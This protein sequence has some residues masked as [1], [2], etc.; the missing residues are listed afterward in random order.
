MPFVKWIFCCVLLAS[1]DTKKEQRATVKFLMHQGNTP[2]QIWCGLQAVYEDRALSKTAVWF[3]CRHLQGGDVTVSIK[4]RPRTGRPRSVRTQENAQK[5]IQFLTTDARKT[6]TEIAEE[7]G[8]SRS[9][10]HNILKK[11]L[12]FSKLAPKFVPHILTDEQ[13]AARVRMCEYNLWELMDDP[14]YLSKV[15]TGDETWVSVFE[16]ETKQSSKHWMKG[17][18]GAVHPQKA[19]HNRSVKKAMLTVFFDSKGMVL[20]QFKAPKE[21][22]CADSYC[23]VLRD[24]RQAI[25]RK[26]PH[27]WGGGC[28]H[29]TFLLH[30]DNAPPH[31]AAVTLGLIGSHNID[32]VAHPPYSPDL[33][34]CDFFLFPRLKKGLRGRRFPN[35]ETMKQA[36][37]AELRSIPQA[38]FAGAID[39]LVVRW[40]KCIEAK[41]EYFEGRH[42]NITPNE[43]DSDQEDDPAGNVMI[44]Q[45]DSEDDQ[46]TLL[47]PCMF[48]EHFQSL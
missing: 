16:M 22:V 47:L 20:S 19:L 6:L 43:A 1:M 28:G 44:H 21:T 40:T 3:W 33:A 18:R 27:L 39:Q 12:K 7:T 26:R 14:N 42:I 10:T 17:G 15:V 46:W 23:E 36:V 9:S 34:P 25:R 48:V 45:D 30:H 4:D 2:I 29:S 11:D 31:T 35:M 5:V 13:K 24:L 8:I 41:G 38:E 37:R 32:M